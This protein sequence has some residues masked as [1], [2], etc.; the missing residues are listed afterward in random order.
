L[1]AI[2][3]LKM[4]FIDLVPHSVDN[5]DRL[6]GISMLWTLAIIG[7]EINYTCR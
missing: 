4:R 5:L 7:V 1:D 6:R 2:A 3:I